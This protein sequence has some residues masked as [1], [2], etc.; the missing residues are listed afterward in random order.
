MWWQHVDQGGDDGLDVGRR[1]GAA[2]VHGAQ[3]Q[4]LDDVIGAVVGKQFCDSR[5][6]GAPGVA[7]TGH[8]ARMTLISSM[9]KNLTKSCLKVVAL[10]TFNLFRYFAVL[11]NV[12]LYETTSQQ[13]HFSPKRV[14]NRAVIIP[15]FAGLGI[16]V[17]ISVKRVGIGIPWIRIHSGIESTAGIGS[18][19]L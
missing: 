11:L 6:Q 3:A 2:G 15:F 4:H 12:L 14:C 13:L 18:T 1:H 10:L 19:L 5:G 16:G 7:A 9:T 17:G 8:L